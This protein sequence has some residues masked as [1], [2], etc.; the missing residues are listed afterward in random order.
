MTLYRRLF[1]PPERLAIPQ[2]MCRFVILIPM[3]ITRIILSFGL[4]VSAAT[5]S[6]SQENKTVTPPPQSI[7]GTDDV[8]LL[9]RNEF[10]I[11]GSVHTNGFGLNYR[12]GWH[13]TGYKKRLLEVEAVNMKHA[14]EIKTQNPLFENSKGYVYG[15]LNVL[16]IIRVGYGFQKTL[17]GKEQRRGVEI[18]L[19][20]M[21]GAS[22]GLAKPVYLEILQPTTDPQ[23]YNITTE[24]YNPLLHTPDNIYG[25]APYFKGFDQTKIYPG[26]YGKV[27]VSFE[28][29]NLE[30]DIKCIETGLAVDV[31]PKVIPIMA[32][33]TNQ[34]VFINLYINFIWGKKWF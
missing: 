14:K 17:Y 5:F 4:L 26:G 2:K 10:V 15:K 30:D 34:Q 16:D 11:G 12:R 7:N 19:L 28:Y 6:F 18:R 27:G 9:Y 23:I 24:Q 21:I 33:T 32:N 13:V 31:Y 20:T 1:S 22:I 3:K 25:R 8:G 29:A